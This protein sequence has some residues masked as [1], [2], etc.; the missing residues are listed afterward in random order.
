FGLSVI[1][2]DNDTPV[3]FNMKADMGP[4]HLDNG[5]GG[6]IIKHYKAKVEAIPGAKIKTGDFSAA[7]TVIVT[8]N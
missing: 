6:R 2:V 4:I 7:M 3:K 5:A 8:Y 1:D